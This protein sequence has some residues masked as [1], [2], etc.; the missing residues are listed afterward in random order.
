[1][2]DVAKLTKKRLGEILREQG[3]INEEHIQEALDRQEETDELM[4]RALIE[5]GYVTEEDIARVLCTQFGLPYMDVQ[6]CLPNEELID[7]IPVSFIRKYSFLPLDQIG[8]VVVIA[9]SGVFDQEF[10]DQL[11]EITDKEIQLVISTRQKIEQS[12]LDQVGLHPDEF[13]INDTDT[14]IEREPEEKELD[15]AESEIITDLAQ[16]TKEKQTTKSESSTTY[17]AEDESEKTKT[18]TLDENEDGEPVIDLESEAERIFQETEQELEQELE[19]HQDETTDQQEDEQET[20]NND[21]E[22]GTD[23]EESDTPSTT[24]KQASVSS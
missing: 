7:Q 8:D 6:N 16:E 13:D 17:S 5:L 3:L 11:R 1:M 12:L 24:E 2:A 10:F 21:D 14:H 20:Q 9:V 15:E 19:Q 18:F 22:S 23:S 4:G